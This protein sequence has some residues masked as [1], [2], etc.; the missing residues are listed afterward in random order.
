MSSLSRLKFKEMGNFSIVNETHGLDKKYN[1]IKP[2]RKKA[3]K[4]KLQKLPE[5]QTDETELKFEVKLE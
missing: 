5:G 2:T 1:S 3:P 4:V